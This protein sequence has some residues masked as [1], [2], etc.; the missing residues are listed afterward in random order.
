MTSFY[1]LTPLRN[2]GIDGSGVTVM[3]PEWGVPDS[4]VLDAYASKFHLPP[5]HVS[6]VSDPSAWGAPV[7]ASQQGYA[8]VAGEAA[9]DLEVVHGL[10][11]GANEIAYEGGDPSKLPVMLEA[12]VTQHR[13]AILSSSVFSSHCERD[14]G[15]KQVAAATDAVFAQAA[16]EGVPS[17][18]PPATAGLSHAFRMARRQRWKRSRSSPRR[19]APMPP[20]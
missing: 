6:V 12:M 18:G 13:G 7:L 1:D 4:T 9:L 17:F 8:E 2:A 3:F 15:A 10:A 19:P 16:S 14:P 11:P 20:R 5:F